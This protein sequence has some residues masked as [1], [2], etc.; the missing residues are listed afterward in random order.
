MAIGGGAVVVIIIA[1]LVVTG[2]TSSAPQ[3]PD[4]YALQ[5]SEVAMVTGVPASA[6]ERNA[7][8]CARDKSC[9]ASA[10]GAEP[11]QKLPPGTS[12]L[13]AGGHP[14]VVYVGANFCP[15]CAGE[16]W[17]IV[18]AMSKFG[19][20]TRLRGTT[21]SSTDVNASTPTFT[22]YGSSYKS[23]YLTFL[24]DEQSTNTQQP[25]QAPNAL[26]QEL[27]NKWDVSPWT[28]QNGSIPFVYLGGKYVVTGIQYDASSFAGE[29]WLTAAEDI[30]SG[31][32]PVSAHAEAAAGFL[33]SDLCTLTHNQPSS[34]CSQVP[35]NL[36]GISATSHINIGSSTK[37]GRNTGSGATKKAKTTV[38]TPAKKG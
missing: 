23:Q 35:S 11:P 14:E 25:L 8:A 13:S 36:R 26:E 34:V 28:S 16:R 32:T 15:Y 24:T 30:T 12:V 20:F 29:P 27:L 4:S 7:E 21:S 2:L 19:T 33:V 1:V 17:A 6:L 37:T 9:F 5:P 3:S 22:F 10:S 31:T 18:M 38:T